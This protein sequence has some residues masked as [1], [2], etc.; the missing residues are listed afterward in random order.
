M[1]DTFD[2][3]L[4]RYYLP[5]NRTSL[6]GGPYRYFALWALTLSKD[7]YR[8][9]RRET[10]AVIAIISSACYMLIFP[11][12]SDSFCGAPGLFK[13]C[14]ANFVSALIKCFIFCSKRKLTFLLFSRFDLCYCTTCQKVWIRFRK[15]FFNE[16]LAK[17]AD[18]L[19]RILFTITRLIFFM[20]SWLNIYSVAPWKMI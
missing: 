9:F 1:S 16:L 4:L 7:L 13:G 8:L 17:S 18:F 10:I 20:A 2:W 19:I 15:G 6:M 12:F 11:V 14:L 3:S 5:Q